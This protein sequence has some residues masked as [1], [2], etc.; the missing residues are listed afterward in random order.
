ML[1]G[2]AERCRAGE[3][4][5]HAPWL[6]KR[7]LILLVTP[8]LA[9]AQ[10]ADR[11]RAVE[12]GLMPGVM[13]KGR[14]V[15]RYTIQERM[16]ALNVNGVSLAVIQNY[17]IGWAKGYGLADVAAK[18]P[19]TADTLFLAGSISKPV[20]AAGA[21]ALVEQG[22]VKLDDDVNRY[23]KSWKVP[24]NEFTK[25][26]KVTLRR[27][28]SHTAGLTVHG[29][30]GYNVA[31]AVPTI[32]QILDGVKPANTPAVRVDL[33][34]GSTYRYSGGG[35]TVAQ[36]MMTEVTGVAFPDFLQRAV[37][38]KAGMRQ[39]TYEN[40]LPQRLAD[41]AA[42]GYKGNGDAI[43]GRY[44]TYPEMA[45]AGLWT[46]A[47]DLARF[48]IEIQKS[49]AR[50]KIL[51]QATIEE[52]LRPEKQNYGLGFSISERDGLKR[53]GHSGTDAGFQ[54]VLMATVDGR[55]LVVM[56]NSENG[57]RL[58]AEIA[59]SVAAAYG[60][61]DKP[62][63][64]EAIAMPPEALAKFAGA[65]EAGRIGRVT[66]RVEG[67]HLVATAPGLGDVALYPESADTFFSLG[68]V[69]DLKFAADG[70]SFTGGNVAAKRVK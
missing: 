69:P 32:P 49:E 58:A 3:G 61:P 66:I 43:P 50:A 55:G 30:P 65:Y 1:S 31:S 24:E 60:W 63:E 62:R 52:M 5:R 56:T 67:D 44:H 18:R 4:G 47:S 20:A 37:L 68:G 53:F 39:S 29:F 45:A 15:P 64:R 57:G 41:V 23:L 11:I 35:Y 16:K 26:Q 10:N 38:A 17:E 19:V 6:V 34:P 42:S 2:G 8:L 40:P 33:V 7:L 13:V 70:S 54:A 14:P 21:L 46:T 9:V 22:K 59:L 36:L 28:L 25:E 12:T 51:S 48:A 27:L